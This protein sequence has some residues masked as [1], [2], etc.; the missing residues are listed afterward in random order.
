MTLIVFGEPGATPLLGVYALE[1]LRLAPDPLG[2]RLVPVL[3][4][5]MEATRSS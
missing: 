4:L 2:R 3:G 5:L 1:G